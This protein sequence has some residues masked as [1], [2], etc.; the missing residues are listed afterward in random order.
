MKKIFVYLVA[1]LI[2]LGLAACRTKSEYDHVSMLSLIAYPEQYDGKKIRV[3]GY[4]S[5]IGFCLSQHSS[6]Y[7]LPNQFFILRFSESYKGLEY[8]EF[9]QY[10]SVE[11]VFIN[12]VQDRVL[13]GDWYYGII[14]EV[15]RIEPSDKQ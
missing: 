15:T 1:I 10:V 7:M 2:L 4:W 9:P 6:D 13:H 3:E 11:G 14:D 5:D 8:S 12:E